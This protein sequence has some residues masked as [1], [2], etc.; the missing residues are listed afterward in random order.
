[1]SSGV[2]INIEIHIAADASTQT[3]E[4]IFRSMQRYVLRPDGAPENDE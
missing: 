2:N 4:D 1:L 3:I